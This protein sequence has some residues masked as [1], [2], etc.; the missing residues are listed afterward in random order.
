MGSRSESKLGVLAAWALERQR[1]ADEVRGLAG[2][3][4][5]FVMSNVICQISS[6]SGG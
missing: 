5:S 3:I 1:S 6:G 4:I 2:V